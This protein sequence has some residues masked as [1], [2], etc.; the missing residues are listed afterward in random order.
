[1]RNR[2]LVLLVLFAVAI[3]LNPVLVAGDDEDPLL[4]GD[5]DEGE[6]KPAPGE[7][8]DEDPLKPPGDVEKPGEAAEEPEDKTCK[9]CTAKK[10]CAAHKEKEE[11]TLGRLK[12]F[13]KKKWKKEQE[14]ERVAELIV[15][16]EEAAA[17]TGEHPQYKSK[18]VAEALAKVLITEKD[19]DVR[20]KLL[21][22]MDDRQRE[23]VC[24]AYLRKYVG[25]K[26]HNSE[27][28][29]YAAFAAIAYFENP[30]LVGFFESYFDVSSDRI[31]NAA[32]DSIGYIGGHAGISSLISLLDEC[33]RVANK[34]S[35]GNSGMGGPWYRIEGNL[36]KLTNH[37][38]DVE[39]SGRRRKDAARYF[40][41]DWKDWWKAGS[42]KYEKPS[43][44][45][46]ERKAW[47][48][49]VRLYKQGAD[50]RKKDKDRGGG[51]GGG[52]GK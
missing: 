34:H 49:R 21:D 11:E 19:I 42:R 31:R 48:N 16:L 35:W 43:K 23:D 24:L 33:I 4:P 12:D 13:L 15:L 9:E 8:G 26:D 41:K 29:F 50:P 5:D 7:P 14:K 22:L 17:L 10:M 47:K 3:A 2:I 1:M 44:T 39:V 20:G 45:D 51:R 25:I 46:Q 6:D 32:I 27:Y 38:P 52:A 18:D 28:M 40:V 36:K 37:I 30:K